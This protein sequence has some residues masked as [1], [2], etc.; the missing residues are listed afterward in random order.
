MAQ[1]TSTNFTKAALQAFPVPAKGRAYFYDTKVRGL[2]LAVTER[3]VK[4]FVVYR[5]A[6]NKPIKVTLGRYPDLSIEQARASASEAI[7]KLARGIN[8]KDEKREAM[9]RS[10]TLGDA[11][12]A[13][14]ASRK[15]LSPRTRYD[16][17]RLLSTYLWDWKDRPLVEITKDMVERRHRQIAKGMRIPSRKSENGWTQVASEAQANYAMRFLRAL[18]NF[19]MIKYED[20]RGRALIAENPVRRLTQTRAWYRVDRRQ[21]VIKPHQ[22]PAWFAAVSQLKSDAVNGKADVVKDY[23]IFLVLTGLRRNE[24]ARMR[25]TDVDLNARTFTIHDTKNKQSHTLPLSDYLYELIKPRVEEGE[26]EY[27]FPGTGQAG[28][29]ME[30]KKQLAK[31]TADSKVSFTLHDL[32]RTFASIADSLDIPAYALKRLLNHR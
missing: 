20:S 1:K 17:T 19:A 28:Y 2:A 8:P 21:T 26:G 24:A 11:L 27:V 4:T 12:K 18:I 31:V 3:G 7:S 9:A 16:Y 15:N 23:L 6:L 5:W 30:P 32:R 25:K 13:F 22:L 14:L 29:L 10:T